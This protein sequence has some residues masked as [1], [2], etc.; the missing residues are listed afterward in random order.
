MS[1][2]SSH[3]TV[4]NFIGRTRRKQISENRTILAYLPVTYDGFNFQDSRAQINPRRKRY[5]RVQI[6]HARHEFLEWALEGLVS[7]SLP[8]VSALSSGGYQYSFK[9]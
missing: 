9:A 3:I 6:I 2:Y 5:S 4:L 8:K 1:F 7:S